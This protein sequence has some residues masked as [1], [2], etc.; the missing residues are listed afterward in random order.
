MNP[1]AGQHDFEQLRRR[2]EARLERAGAKYELRITTSA[3]DARHWAQQAR[4]FDRVAVAGGDGTVMEA[5]SGVAGR[6]LPLALIPTGTANLLA[7]AIGVPRDPEEALELALSGDAVPFDVGYLPE[8]QLHFALAASAGWHADLVKDTSRRLKNRLGFLAY[9]LT[10]MKNLF[11][12]RRSVI[13]LKID[14]EHR[15]MRA[16]TVLVINIGDLGARLLVGR[17]IDPHDGKLDVV[18]VAPG[19]LPRMLLRML[20]RR[21]RNSPDVRFHSARRVRLDARPPLPLQIDGELIGE[22]PFTVEV[23]PDGALLV[24]PHGYAN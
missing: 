18:V 14:G 19:G 13:D 22:T 20:R 10:G 24:V 11:T 12:P 9:V 4:S 15:R 16:N 5:V 17:H 8:H 3:G 7:L 23:V 1:V 2:L 21:V 6:P